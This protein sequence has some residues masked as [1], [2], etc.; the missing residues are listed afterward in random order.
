MFFAAR[1]ISDEIKKASENPKIGKMIEV[2]NS[3]LNGNYDI[4]WVSSRVIE[5]LRK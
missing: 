3:P 5:R 1:R 4:Y 2:L